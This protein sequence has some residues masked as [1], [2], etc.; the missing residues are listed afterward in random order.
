MAARYNEPQRKE[1]MMRFTLFGTALVL[2]AAGL[3]ALGGEKDKKLEYETGYTAYFVKN[4][5]PLKDDSTHLAITSK[6]QFDEVFGVGFTMKKPKTIDPKAF[7]TKVAAVVVKKGNAPWSYAVEKVNAADGVLRVEYK[8]TAGDA[9]S[10]KFA[11][12]LIVVV[13]GRD[14]KRVVFVENG[15]E[16]GKVEVKK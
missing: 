7:E 16:V 9:T 12:P 15:K 6:A 2:F 4:T 10:A 11:S 8:A 1:P 5:F 13:A 14:Y 3:P